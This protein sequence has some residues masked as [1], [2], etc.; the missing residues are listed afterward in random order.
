[1]SNIN[2]EIERQL[3]NENV[4]MILYVLLDNYAEHEI[5]I[6]PEAVKTDEMGFSPGAQV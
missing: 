3:R 6:L 1:M 5:A 4:D 2:I